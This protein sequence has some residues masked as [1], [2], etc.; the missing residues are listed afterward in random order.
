MASTI[1]E[2]LAGKISAFDL[3]NVPS[4]VR[5]T[6][7]RCL[8]DISGVTIA[9]SNTDSANRARSHC[10]ETYAPG[11][12]RLIGS[13]TVLSA[14]GAALAN[15][16]AAHALDFDDNSYA[17]VV[18]G[19]A[20]VF[21]AVL[22]IA[23]QQAVSGK[24]L[25]DAF[26]VG[27]ETEFALGKAFT[28]SIYDKGW[29]TTSVLGGFGAVAGAVRLMHMEPEAIA[30]A[31]S[32]VAVGAGAIRALRGADTKHFYCGR[33][34]EAGVVAAM[35]A[36]RGGSAPL[37]AFEDR[38]G[39]LRIINDSLF[40]DE[41]IEQLGLGFFLKDPGVDI[42]RYPVCYASHAAIDAVLE[43]L[44]SNKLAPED[45]TDVTCLVPP[46]VA[47]NLSFTAPV[48]GEQAQFSMQFSIAA[49]ILFGNVGLDHL[50]Q[51]TLE[52]ADLRDLMHRVTMNVSDLPS[53]A[54]SRTD[55]SPEWAKVSVITQA[56]MKH[57][58]FCGSA[59]GSSAHPLSD[60]EVDEKFIICAEQAI[61]PQHVSSCLASLR[62][63][64]E[65][66]DVRSL[67]SFEAS[68][69]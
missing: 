10:A 34:A 69:E 8:I 19:S 68:W 3:D 58:I 45:I 50:R 53:G 62:S 49:A 12:C 51:G 48:T 29:W 18:H 32:F 63:L 33:A 6:A 46:V 44:N 23:Q 67:F 40:E 56:G 27:L 65:V 28:N 15:G 24:D 57:E 26:I 7:S 47:S 52:N 39:V 30:R 5:A 55:I 41:Y 35:M 54:E 20:V 4:D 37:D 2:T 21:P 64:D 60:T 11:N 59:R 61:E 14:P 16:V 1:V 22:S 36:D 38:N 9:G 13:S 17:G 25:L 42:K 43:I 31:L 66:C